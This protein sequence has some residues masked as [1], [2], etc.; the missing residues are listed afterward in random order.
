M[1]FLFKRTATL[2]LA[3]MLAAPM[4][5]AAP[6]KADVNALLKKFSERLEQLEKRN[7]ELEQQLTQ[8]RTENSAKLEPRIKAIE[9]QNAKIEKGLENDGVSQYEPELTARL[10]AVE[11]QS[12]NMQKSARTVSALDGVTAGVSLTTVAQHPGEMPAGSHIHNSQLNYRGDVTVSLPLP[13][14]G[15]IENKMVAA[16]RLGQGIGLNGVRSFAKPNASAFRVSSTSPDD[17]VAVLG[18]AWYQ[19]T[20]PLPF[21]GF[22]PRSREKLEINFG[23]MDPFSFFDQNAVANDETRQFLNTVFVHNPL[24]DAGGDIGVDANGFTPGFRVSYLNEVNKA[25]PWR[26]SFGVFGAG[27]GANYTRFFSSP[28]VIAQVEKQFKSFGGLNGNVRAYYWRNGQAAQY[29][30]DVAAHSG[31]GI[32]ADQRVSD[33]VALFGRYGH[34]LTGRVSFDRALT[35]G[36]EFGGGLWQ[37]GADALGVSLGWL[38]TSNQFRNDAPTLADFGF[39]ASNAERVAEIYYRYRVNKQFELSP[40][41]QLI[42]RPAG[43]SDA[44]LV[45]LFG[46]R[47]QIV[48]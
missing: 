11:Y 10:K 44:S 5:Q 4:V 38:R 9:E 41:L 18:Q 25:E 42:S 46:V 29:S 35:F 7:A 6:A 8:L 19:A 39:A 45:K 22:K 31:W 30:G 3:T 12:L 16:F 28:L 33:N 24:L 27:Q 48:Y 14:S 21:G 40:D 47:A 26:L 37:R 32:S 1:T 20:I 23:K 2:L 43:N 17:S 13:N 15:D 36:A 34:Q